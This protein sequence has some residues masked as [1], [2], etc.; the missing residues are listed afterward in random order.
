METDQVDSALQ[1]S[2]QFQ[3]SVGVSRRVVVSGKHRVFKA[4]SS[5]SAEI[6]LLDEPDN[7]GD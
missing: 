3:Q 5:L 4:D 1:A 6:I 2:E 7:L